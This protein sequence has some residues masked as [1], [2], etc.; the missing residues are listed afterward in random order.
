[1][2]NTFVTFIP[3]FDPFDAGKMASLLERTLS[4]GQLDFLRLIAAEAE[5][6]RMPLYIIGGFVRDLLLGRPSVDFDLVVEGDAIT[7][8]HGL[9]EKYGG[10]VTSHVP[11]RTAQWYPILNPERRWPAVLD[12]ISARSET[13]AHPGAL[14]TVKAGDLSDDLRRRDFTVNTLALRLNGNHFGELRDDLGGVA[15]LEQGRLHALHPGSYRDDPTRILRLVRYEQ[16]YGFKV[17][18][19]DLTWIAAAKSGLGELSGERLRH[20]LDLI[21]AEERSVAMLARLSGLDVLGEIH[22]SL[23]WDDSLRPAFEALDRPEPDSWRGVPDLLR[24]PRRVGLGYLVWLGQ[25]QSAAI[26]TLAARLDFSAP[27]RDALLA[28]SALYADLPA[29]VDAKT[30][31][32]T[33]RLDKVPLLALCALSLVSVSIR[34]PAPVLQVQVSTS[35]S[36]DNYLSTWRSIK[37]K[38][39]G[40][41]LI[42]RGL[43]PGPAFQVILDRL[44]AA[45]LDGEIGSVAEEMQLLDKLIKRV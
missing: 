31:R 41:D 22:P 44:R 29:L 25:M 27:L 14:P 39:T 18:E 19:E 32:L 6:Q 11:F 23:A 40:D 24:V 7:L 1:V 5:T 38:T 26:E 37:P 17:A 9:S 12:L 2:Y 16:R 28:L 21:L 30:S 33:L 8:A 42:E 35:E 20:E 10:E 34:L 4:S 43:A 3:S 13:Y 45:W 15:D 36:V